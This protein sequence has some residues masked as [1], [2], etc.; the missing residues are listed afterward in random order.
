[1]AYSGEMTWD[2]VK[3]IVEKHCQDVIR[4]LVLG[5]EAYQDLLEIYQYSGGDDTEFAKLLFTTDTPSQLQID[6]ATDAR[7]AMVAI[8]Q[9]YRVLVW[10]IKTHIS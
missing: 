8:H 2:K 3:A 10:K 4:E 9:L 6:Q 1:M 7:K 5:E